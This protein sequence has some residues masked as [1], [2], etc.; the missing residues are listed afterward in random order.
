MTVLPYGKFTEEL[1]ECLPLRTEEGGGQKISGEIT[2]RNDKMA[3][4]PQTKTASDVASFH[5]YV[6]ASGPE[7]F[8]CSESIKTATGI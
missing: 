2:E 5:C 7:T 3:A 6:L 1:P 4:E 8:E